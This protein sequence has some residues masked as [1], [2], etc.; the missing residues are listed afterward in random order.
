MKKTLSAILAL[1]LSLMAILSCGSAAL[2]EEE[3]APMAV[4]VPCSIGD[5]FIELCLKGLYQLS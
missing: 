3:P 5:P 1:M 2:A 4:L